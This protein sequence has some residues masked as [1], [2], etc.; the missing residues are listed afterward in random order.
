MSSEAPSAD[1]PV[2]FP[3]TFVISGP[4]GVGKGT[5]V[6]RLLETTDGLWLSRSWT[7]RDPRPGEAPDAYNFVTREEFLAHVENGGFLEWVEFLDY[8][9]G[10]PMPTP[11]EGDVVILE[12]DI[13]GAAQIEAM[14]PAAH[15]IFI[16]TPSIE[17]QE[18]RLRGRGDTDERVLMRLDKAVVE[19]SA[20]AE[21]GCVVLVNDDLDTT[22]GELRE[23]IDAARVTN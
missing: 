7:T 22:V 5:V 6:E 23:L 9:Q 14:N 18:R 21:L 4:G 8:L 19:R 1:Q 17:E 10:T 11:P 20:A 2:D 16:D 15:L 13:Q 3:V 12:I